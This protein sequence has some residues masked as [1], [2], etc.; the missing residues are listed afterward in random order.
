M[1]VGQQV[2]K[3]GTENLKRVQALAGAK[4]HLVVC[5]MPIKKGAVENLVELLRA[6]VKDAWLLVWLYLLA[7]QKSGL[8]T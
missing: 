3:K 4:N 5:L 1:P 7:N 8:K 2:Y 6:P